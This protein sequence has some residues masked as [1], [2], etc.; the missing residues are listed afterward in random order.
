[1]QIQPFILG[2]GRAGHAIEKSLDFL[3][4]IEPDWQIEPVIWISREDPLEAALGMS[5]GGEPVL[6]IAN[7]HGM[8][9]KSILRAEKADF[10]KNYL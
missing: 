1:M 10:Q 6:F 4:S 9:A 5:S 3:R 2:R 8:H 7:P